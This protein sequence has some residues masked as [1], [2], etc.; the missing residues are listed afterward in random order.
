MLRCTAAGLIPLMNS[1]RYAAQADAL[2]QA[3]H[4]A[5]AHMI[6]HK[7]Y[8]LLRM[9]PPRMARE[10]LSPQLPALAAKQLKSGL[11]RG[12]N[13]TENTY[14][15]LRALA[16][17]GLLEDATLPYAPA[18]Q[19]GGRQDAFALLLKRDFGDGLTQEDASALQQLLQEVAAKQ[20]A[21]GSFGGTVTGTVIHL[22]WLLDLG[23]PQ[24][25][26]VIR[27]GADYLL[28]QRK[29]SLQGMHTSDPYSLTVT[30]VYTTGNRTGEFEAALA[31]KPEWVPRHVCFHTMAII[32]NAVCLRLL[33]ELGL[34]SDAGVTAAL[35]S[36]YELYSRHGGLCAT[37]IKKPYIGG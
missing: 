32:P 37:N 12:K 25:D 6:E 4:G 22:E 3:E 16:H 13:S 28:S 29:P 35:I 26:F 30:N 18:A 8:Y 34:E 31:F 21:D 19:L 14:H 36:L 33:L 20:S 1:Q 15:I 9:L 27:R 5:F 7:S 10:L 2:F 17:A 24:A 23:M 11:W